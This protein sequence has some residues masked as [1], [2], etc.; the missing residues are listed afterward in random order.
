M[1]G[2]R[3]WG[4][5]NAHRRESTAEPRVG[6]LGGVLRPVDVRAV[7]GKVAVHDAPGGVASLLQAGLQPGDL[8]AHSTLEWT[9]RARVSL[10]RPPQGSTVTCQQ[11]TTRLECH[12]RSRYDAKCVSILG[13][14]YT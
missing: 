7:E 2:F 6:G 5:G 3:V 14:I 8:M 10:S 4:L 9:I 13:K 1:L 12:G 11:L